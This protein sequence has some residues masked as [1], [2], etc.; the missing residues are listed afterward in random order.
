MRPVWLFFDNLERRSKVFIGP[1]W[2][3]PRMRLLSI[4]FL[5]AS[6]IPVACLWLVVSVV[7]FD[8]D[9]EWMADYGA[10]IWLA[11]VFGFPLVWFV[12]L[13]AD[14]VAPSRRASNPEASDQGEA[15]NA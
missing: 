15:G 11:I 3:Y 2:N 14:Q 6:F 4:Y 1:D 8:R 10:W 9:G 7:G 12:K 13:C 5:V